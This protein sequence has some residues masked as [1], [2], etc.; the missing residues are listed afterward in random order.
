MKLCMLYLQR[1]TSVHMFES[2][3]KNMVEINVKV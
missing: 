1:Q 2:V 3:M